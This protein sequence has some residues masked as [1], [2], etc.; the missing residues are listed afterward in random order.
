MTISRH[1]LHNFLR[2]RYPHASIFLLDEEYDVPNRGEVEK[3]YNSFIHRM[4][5]SRLTAWVK[6]VGDCDK[7]AWLLKASAIIN[8]WLGGRKN[9]YPYGLVC[10][11][12]G[13]DKGRGHAIN[14]I[15]WAD[16][17]VKHIDE[18]EPQP[19]NGFVETTKKERESAWLVI[20]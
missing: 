1:E 6:N 2:H 10:Y 9:S 20:V 8:A 5:V 16:G 15:V 12:I 4:A 17:E 7:W 13:G 3:L 19:K 14:N 18:I 11:F